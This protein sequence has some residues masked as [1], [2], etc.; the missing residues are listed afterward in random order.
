M[1]SKVVIPHGKSIL[2]GSGMVTAAK[3]VALVAVTWGVV[4]PALFWSFSR[5]IN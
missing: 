5:L 3:V 1:N 4:F 2:G